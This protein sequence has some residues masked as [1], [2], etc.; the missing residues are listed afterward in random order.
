MFSH[1]CISVCTPYKM[2]LC[3]LEGRLEGQS[4]EIF[5]L[6]WG[7]VNDKVPHLDF[8]TLKECTDLFQGRDVEGVTNPFV[9]LSKNMVVRK[10]PLMTVQTT[11]NIRI[12]RRQMSVCRM[13]DTINKML[14]ILEMEAETIQLNDIVF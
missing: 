2:L 7:I 9:R 14:E 5:E 11:K 3:E 10:L 8:F 6:L 13:F 12:R 4:K 1:M